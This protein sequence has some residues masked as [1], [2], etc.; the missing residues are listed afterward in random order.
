MVEKLIFNFFK[1]INNLK[2]ILKLKKYI[3]K[4]KLK[5]FFR[6]I[7]NCSIENIEKK[8]FIIFD[9]L[10]YFVFIFGFYYLLFGIII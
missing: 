10:L 2:I 7:K 4:V 8:C 9:I 1:Y 6:N 5:I 3:V